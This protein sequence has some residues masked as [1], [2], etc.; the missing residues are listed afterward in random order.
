MEK[1]VDSCLHH[2]DDSW[3]QCN[4]RWDVV[5]VL[6]HGH[7]FVHFYPRVRI[8]AKIHNSCRAPPRRTLIVYSRPDKVD[9][10]ALSC[11]LSP[12]Q[13]SVHRHNPLLYPPP[14]RDMSK[15]S[16]HVYT[17]GTL[18]MECLLLPNIPSPLSAFDFPTTMP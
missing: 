18:T 11:F 10:L 17:A 7:S 12:K 14:S 6:F 4:D 5:G 3:H 2:Y 15:R 8:C 9:F 16:N 1:V 13:D